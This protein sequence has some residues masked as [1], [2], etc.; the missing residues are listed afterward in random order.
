MK[1]EKEVLKHVLKAIIK[2]EKQVKYSPLMYQPKRP[3]GLLTSDDSKD[4]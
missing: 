2:S 3:K 4:K 1:K